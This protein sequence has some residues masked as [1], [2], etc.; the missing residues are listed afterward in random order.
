MSTS[1][2]YAPET[3]T[4][5]QEVLDQVWNALPVEQRA[6]IAKSEMAQRI[7]RRAAEGERDPVKLRAAAMIGSA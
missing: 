7:L 2:N 4:L 3:L 1:G 6:D 5:L